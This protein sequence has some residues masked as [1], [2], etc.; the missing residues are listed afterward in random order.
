M[1]IYVWR[2]YDC[3]EEVEVLRKMSESEDPPQEDETPEGACEHDW[4]RRLTTATVNTSKSATMLDGT[5]R[6]GWDD[7]KAITKLKRKRANTH[8]DQGRAEIDSEIRNRKISQTR[9]KQEQVP[10]SIKE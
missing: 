6:P 3:E 9:G 8:T 2:C 1:P 7:A 10:S 4:Q 5:A